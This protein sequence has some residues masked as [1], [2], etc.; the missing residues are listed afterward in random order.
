[1]APMELYQE[2][3]ALVP[4]EL[5]RWRGFAL[6]GWWRRVGATLL[7]SF[8][9]GL[10]A[11]LTIVALGVDVDRL[12]SGSPGD[13]AWLVILGVMLAA[14][15]YFPAIMRAT[16]GRTLGKMATRIRVVRTDGQPMSLARATWREVVLKTLVVGLIPPFLWP[17]WLLD[18]L[19]PLWD[20]ENRAIHDMLAGTRVVRTDIPRDA[21]FAP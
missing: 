2:D 16:D 1:M 10:V 12:Y 8:L 13:E 7:D 11:N 4:R 14:I 9:V 5:T 18:D 20:R 3:R 6:S 19:W 17:L 15:A 21:R